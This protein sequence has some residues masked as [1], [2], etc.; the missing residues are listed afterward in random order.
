MDQLV[1]L[2]TTTGNGTSKPMEGEGA[3]TVGASKPVQTPK[4]Y[5][6]ITLGERL[7]LLQSDLF[8]LQ[9]MIGVQV[10]AAGEDGDLHFG[11]RVNFHKLD[12]IDGNITLDGKPVNPLLEEKP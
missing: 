10:A 12:F 6:V 3:A 4:G 9:K 2:D 8:D 11:V 7:S 1:K 5:S